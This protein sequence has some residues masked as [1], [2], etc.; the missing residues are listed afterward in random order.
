MIQWTVIQV[1]GVAPGPLVSHSPIINSITQITVSIGQWFC[2][3]D[4]FNKIKTMLKSNRTNICIIMESS[5]LE[6][7]FKMFLYI[8]YTCNNYFKVENSSLEIPQ[9]FNFLSMSFA[10][11]CL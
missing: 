5:F 8:S 7:F 4:A 1:S 11:T 10:F 3:R 9:P 2:M 6:W